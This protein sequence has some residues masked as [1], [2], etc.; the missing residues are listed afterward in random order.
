VLAAQWDHV[1]LQGD[2]GPIKISLLDLFAPEEISRYA[3][4]VDAAGTPDELCA[5]FQVPF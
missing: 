3:R 5:L 4:A 2:R 1:T